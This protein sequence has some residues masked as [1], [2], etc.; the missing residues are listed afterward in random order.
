MIAVLPGGEIK[1]LL[2]DPDRG[3][4]LARFDIPTYAAEGD[5]FVRVVMVLKDGS[6]K[7]LRLRY[8]VDTTAPKGTAQ[9]RL[10]LGA[11]AGTLPMLR[12]SVDADKDTAR[13]AAL[14]P[15]GDRVE[16]TRWDDSGRQF[17]RSGRSVGVP[18]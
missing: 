12:L 11:P 14:L 9:T 3:E 7:T 1:R 10:A 16:M 18:E 2:F 4:W 5:Y 15:W 8:Q 13:A 17:W 6:R